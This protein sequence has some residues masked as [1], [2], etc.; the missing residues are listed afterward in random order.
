MEL[1]KLEEN[2]KDN[3]NRQ[4]TTLTMD[5]SEPKVYYISYIKIIVVCPC[6][7]P[8]VRPSVSNKW[9]LETT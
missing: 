5:S 1:S 3:V 4:D 6:V 2:K 7:R 8:S 9:S